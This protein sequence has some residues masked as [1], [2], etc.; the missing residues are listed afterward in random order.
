MVD[1]L[2]IQYNEH[3]NVYFKCYLWPEW[4]FVV[5]VTCAWS[6]VEY[7]RWTA[8]LWPAPCWVFSERTQRPERSS[9]P[10]QKVHS[11]HTYLR[12]LHRCVYS[13]TGQWFFS[14]FE[15]LHGAKRISLSQ[16]CRS[17]HQLLKHSCIANSW[18]S[19]FAYTEI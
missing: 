8:V 10:W 9:S 13:Q 18:N 19:L 4:M 17:V 5:V 1:D 16:S 6:C 15:T 14:M 7:R 12:Q 11:D 2:F 3:E